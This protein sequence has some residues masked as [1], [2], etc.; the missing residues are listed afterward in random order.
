MDAIGLALTGAVLQEFSVTVDDILD[1]VASD[2]HQSRIARCVGEIRPTFDTDR[3]FFEL[4]F[5][6][7]PTPT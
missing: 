6:T 4:A 7:G 1:A 3:D 2:V 5:P